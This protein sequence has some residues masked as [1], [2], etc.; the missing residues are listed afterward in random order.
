MSISYE[1]TRLADDFL[2]LE[3]PRWHHGEILVADVWDKKL[4]KLDRSGQRRL[5]HDMSTSPSGIDFLPDG[6]PVVVS[7]ED[8]RIL[9]LVGDKL[10]V[11]ADLSHIATHHLND[12]LADDQGRIYVGNWGYNI[13]AGAPPAPTDIYLVQPDGAARAVADNLEF[14]NGMAIINQGRTLVVAETWVKRLTAFDRA[15]DGSLSNRRLFADMKHRQPDGMC[16]DAEDAIWAGCYNTGE[17]VRVLDGGEVTHSI[18]C[19]HH[20]IACFLGG[21][22]GRKL[23][24]CTYTG[25]DEDLEARR[26]LAALYSVQVD[27]PGPAH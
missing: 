27:V 18:K 6:T 17:F 22:D 4:Y 21:S 14:P 24:C 10:I 13:H 8:R 1:P 20:A 7:Q 9:K 3:S 2:F 15:A 11:H 5:L 23:L 16:A 25:N 26:R 19:G 12:M